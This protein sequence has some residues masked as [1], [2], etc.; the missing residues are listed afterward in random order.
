MEDRRTL[1]I[2]VRRYRQFRGLSTDQLAE[3]VKL[4]KKTIERLERGEEAAK[5]IGLDYLLKICHELDVSMEELFMKNGDLLAVRFV[6]SDRNIKTLKE[7][8][9][10]ICDSINEN[11]KNKT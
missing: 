10:I 5:N 2:N 8:I 3:R 9:T 11:R 4:T 1:G 6:I 7:L